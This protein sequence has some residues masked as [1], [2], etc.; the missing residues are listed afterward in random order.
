MIRLLPPSTIPHP[1]RPS[2]L[3]IVA[4]VALIVL[5]VKLNQWL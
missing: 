1:W 4:Q 3:I 5:A 2:L